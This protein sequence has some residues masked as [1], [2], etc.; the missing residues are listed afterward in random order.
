MCLKTTKK[1]RLG[2]GI[3]LARAFGRPDLFLQGGGG[4]PPLEGMGVDKLHP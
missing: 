4:H 1:M 3:S 2:L